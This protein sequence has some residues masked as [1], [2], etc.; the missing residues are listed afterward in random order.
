VSG[1]HNTTLKKGEAVRN[2]LAA[3]IFAL[4]P[5]A[6]DAQEF[7]LGAPISDFVISDMSGRTVKY[8][9]VK[10]GITV[11]M[12]FSTRCPISNAFNYRR[13]T[14]YKEFAGPVTFIAVD[15][16]ANQSLDE[17]RE[18]AHA[19][20]FD[21]P[22]YKDVDNVVADRFGA[23]I[24]TETYAIDSSGIVRYHGYLEDSPNPTR[25]KHQGL[26]HA[27]EELLEGKPVTM[28]ETKAVGCNIRR[29]RR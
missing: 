12:F 14:L 4:T 24:T 7:R 2:V 1:A 25:A 10:G 3:L 17:V 18:Y 22:V 6:L 13:N 27:I 11:V 19:V 15:S 5:Q 20:E 28:P 29:L 8:S 9:P 23:Q 26:R 16:N 21:F